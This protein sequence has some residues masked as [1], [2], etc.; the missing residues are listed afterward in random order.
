MVL[1]YGDVAKAAGVETGLLVRKLPPSSTVTSSRCSRKSH[2]YIATT[3][4]PK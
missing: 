4:I 2:Q 1:G 3:I